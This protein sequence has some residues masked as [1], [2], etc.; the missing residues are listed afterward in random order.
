MKD[1]QINRNIVIKMVL[2]LAIFIAIAGSACANAPIGWATTNDLGENGTIGGGS[3]DIVI[4]TT[5]DEL[6]SYAI[7]SK[8]LTIFI[9]GTIEGSESVRV[10]SHKSIIGLGDDA[11][12]I[13]IG[14]DVVGQQNIIVRNLT[15]KDVKGPADAIAMRDTH[16]IWID[17]CDLSNARDGL[18]DLTKGCDYITVS[19]TRFSDHDKVSLL[20]SG[21]NEFVDY[22]KNHA[23]YYCNLWENVVQR[24]PRVGYGRAHVFN[25]YYSNVSSYAIGVHTGAR[26]LV[27]NSYFVNTKNPFS[28]MYRDEEWDA[29]YADIEGIG[30]IFESSTGNKVGTNRSFDP[31]FYYD[32]AFK[33]IDAGEVP[34]EVKARSGPSSQ[35]AQ[36]VIPVPGNGVI[37]VVSAKPELTWVDTREIDS[38]NVYFGTANNFSFK[39][40]V[41]EPAFDP[42]VLNPD[43]V[44]YWR[45]DAVIADE[46]IEGEM[47]RFKTAPIQASKPFPIDGD[48]DVV[49]YYPQDFYTTKPLELTWVGGFGAA[50]HD[51]YLGTS[52]NLISD[53]FI[54]RTE[55]PV[56]APGRLQLGQH[57]YW[58]VDTI[59]DDGTVI[60]GST[61]S[62]ELAALYIGTGRTEAEDMVRSGRYF[63][64]YYAP[65][66]ENWLF[67]SNDWMVKIESGPGTLS[68]IWD[69][70][71]AVCDVVVAY[72]DQSAG[73]GKFALYVD[74]ELIESWIG[75]INNNRINTHQISD[76]QLKKGDE[77]RIE[78]NSDSGMLSRIDYLDIEVK[79]K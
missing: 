55:E 13:G 78:A 15:I 61:W 38:W 75:D 71:A 20:N 29:N 47:W 66:P 3:G 44:Y 11:T 60:T 54:G 52:S 21:T 1:G 32:Y 56:L 42:G 63:L 30:N 31:N 73:K 77:I 36:L 5:K 57:Y 48:L 17:H 9:S 65:G 23:T 53:D 59:L 58:R 62:F 51:V 16:H 74:D 67:P 76:V 43:T 39:T 50:V 10:A 68:A 18:L 45:I 69:D 49:P 70:K 35:Y 4:A 22:G 41:H 8:P 2:S 26:V 46:T 40:N 33:L 79:D 7:Q 25:N 6:V 19:W 12:L 24:N 64:E 27:E 28:Q 37:D 34:H 72:L 14:L